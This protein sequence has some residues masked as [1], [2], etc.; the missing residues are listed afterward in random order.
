M[1]LVFCTKCGATLKKKSSNLS[2][3]S[4]CGFHAY[5]NPTPCNGLI[6]YNTNQEILLVKRSANPYKNYWDLPGGFIELNETLEQSIEREIK[7]ELGIELKNYQYFK[8]YFDRY[9]Y[10]T[11][12]YYTL[13]LIFTAKIE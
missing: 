6:L 1:D 11:S 12:N 9:L 4:H 5:L 3:C 8:S 10:Q 7:E 13:G 2:I